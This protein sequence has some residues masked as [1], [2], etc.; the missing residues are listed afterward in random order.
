MLKMEVDN[1]DTLKKQIAI[2]RKKLERSEH[3]RKLIEKDR[4]S[5]V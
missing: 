3:S 4:K 2:L 5:V 1:K